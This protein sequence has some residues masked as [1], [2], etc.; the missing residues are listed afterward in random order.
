VAATSKCREKTK[1]PILTKEPEEIPPSYVPLYLP[2]SLAPSSTP[3]P[4]TSD[5]EAQGI[6]TPVISGTEASGASTPLTPL[7]PMDSIPTPSQP[8]LT[9]HP[10]FSQGHLPSLCEDPSSPQVPTALQMPL[11]KVQGPMY[12]DQDCQIQGG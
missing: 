12:Y 9:P 11:R 10:P 7:S 5:G 4:L 2:L 3:S 6:V 8:V 1:V